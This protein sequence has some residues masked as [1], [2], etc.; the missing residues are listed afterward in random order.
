MHAM[1]RVSGHAQVLSMCIGLIVSCL[2]KGSLFAMAVGHPHIKRHGSN[3]TRTYRQARR[4][5]TISILGNVYL[6]CDLPWN[7]KF[8]C[9]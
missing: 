2:T 4:K 9:D 7:R 5:I 8:V 6:R 1:Q 3:G